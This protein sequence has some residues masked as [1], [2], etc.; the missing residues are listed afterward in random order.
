MLLFETIAFLLNMNDLEGVR[1]IFILCVLLHFIVL[2]GDWLQ[3]RQM[4]IVADTKL[5]FAFNTDLNYVRKSC[6]NRRS[7]ILIGWNW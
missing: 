7:V 6:R 2:C 3:C 1:N 4:K 5:L